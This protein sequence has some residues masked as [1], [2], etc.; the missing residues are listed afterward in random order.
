MFAGFTFLWVCNK[1]PC[2]ISWGRRYI[3]ILDVDG[4]IPVWSTDFDSSSEMLGTFDLQLNDFLSCCGVYLNSAGELVVDV[5][6]DKG[7]RMPT[8]KAKRSKVAPSVSQTQGLDA[9]DVASVSDR[10]KQKLDI[11]EFK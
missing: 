4:V 11:V 6:C 2:F 1:Q 9:V 10:L 7:C 3:I 8:T 5:P